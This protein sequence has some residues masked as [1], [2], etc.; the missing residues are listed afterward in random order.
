MYCSTEALNYNTTYVASVY[1]VQTLI[2]ALFKDVNITCEHDYTYKLGK[3]LCDDILIYE[4]EI[5]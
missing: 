1:H 4:N 2:I 5:S 3:L